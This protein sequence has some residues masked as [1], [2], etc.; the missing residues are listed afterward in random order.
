M[1][2]YENERQ[3]HFVVLR[4]SKCV[5]RSRDRHPFHPNE[6]R[7]ILKRFNDYRQTYPSLHIK[8]IAQ[9]I[10]KELKEQTF[11]NESMNEDVSKCTKERTWKSVCTLLYN[12]RALQ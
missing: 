3:Q 5:K 9:A 8:E 7:F 6:K 10:W 2:T 11:D 4:G 1:S 12:Q